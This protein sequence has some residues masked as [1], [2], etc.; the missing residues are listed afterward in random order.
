[1]GKLAFLHR[2]WRVLSP[3][4]MG[5][6]RQLGN[7][8]IMKHFLI[9]LLLLTSS[10]GKIYLIS[11]GV[12]VYD[13][14]TTNS[15]SEKDIQDLTNYALE[16]YVNADSNKLYGYQVFLVSEVIRVPK[17]DGSGYRLADGY[18]DIKSKV[19]IV[20]VANKC[21]ADSGFIH[22]MGHVFYED[23]LHSDKKFWEYVFMLE[24]DVVKKLCVYGDVYKSTKLA[25]N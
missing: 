15:P 24:I 4:R 12:V 5:V 17:A 3:R 19:V 18:T 20:T 14:T 9:C 11:P 16:N 21:L 1:M 6:D 10:C 23:A 25:K 7:V 8:I 2:R 22:E 13:R